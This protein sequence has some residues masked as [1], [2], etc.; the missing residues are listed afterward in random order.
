MNTLRFKGENLPGKPILVAVE[1][2]LATAYLRWSRLASLVPCKY[3]VFDSRTL[4]IVTANGGLPV[5]S[6]MGV[7]LSGLSHA[8][9]VIRAGKG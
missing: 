8:S 3:F 2:D 6:H 9:N 7:N 1:R 4:Q 5:A